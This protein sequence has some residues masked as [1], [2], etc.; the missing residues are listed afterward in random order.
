ME[1]VFLVWMSGEVEWL[2]VHPMTPTNILSSI[3]QSHPQTDILLFKEDQ[4]VTVNDVIVSG[5]RLSVLATPHF[6][7]EASY[8]HR[9]ETLH[10]NSVV[11]YDKFTEAIQRHHAIIA[12]GSV[13]SVFADFSSSDMDIYVKHEE[14][15]GL[16]TFFL[17]QGY[18]IRHC[19]EVFGYDSTFMH[20]S[21]IMGRVNLRHPVAPLPLDV[22]VI[23][24]GV[25]LLDVVRQFDLSICQVW[26]DG[27][28]VHGFH[29]DHVLSRVGTLQSSYTPHF[30]GLNWFIINRMYKYVSRGFRIEVQKEPSVPLLFEP[31]PLDNFHPNESWVVTTMFQFIFHHIFREFVQPFAN[32]H[33][34]SHREFMAYFLMKVWPGQRSMAHTQEIFSSELLQAWSYLFY[35][36]NKHCKHFES[37]RAFFQEPA[38]DG[39]T[40]QMTIQTWMDN[41][42][43]SFQE[44]K[45]GLE[46]EI[47]DEE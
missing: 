47:M 4:P 12:G 34:K 31:T 1:G 29:H 3:Q 39:G 25:D 45:Q 46:E 18:Q 28:A 27:R 22:L 14:S 30:Y 2:P 17:Q 33:V 8:T 43:P 42:L 41:V 35:R 11:D 26:W 7:F 44:W 6:R 24:S 36:H 16:I 19:Q 13:V 38:D 32:D 5:D 40:C 20:R 10:R 23:E 21:R 15:F 37:I 9:F